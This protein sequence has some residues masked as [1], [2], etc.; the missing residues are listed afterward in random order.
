MADLCPPEPP[1]PNLYARDKVPPSPPSHILEMSLHVCMW[2]A[3]RDGPKTGINGN[4]KGAFGFCLMS[5]WLFPSFLHSSPHPYQYR[6]LRHLS[7]QTHSLLFLCTA[8]IH[9]TL[10]LNN[11]S[12]GCPN[13]NYFFC[14][15]SANLLFYYCWSMQPQSFP[16]ECVCVCVGERGE[17]FTFSLSVGRAWAPFIMTS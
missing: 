15:T 2:Q 9:Q 13:I 7:R 10:Q 4:E 6:S 17:I 5:H 11:V 14:L 1:P 16:I 8:P 3:S 12:S